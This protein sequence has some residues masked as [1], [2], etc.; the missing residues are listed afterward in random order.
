M[1]LLKAC[2]KFCQL[3]KACLSIGNTLPDSVRLFYFAGIKPSLVH[4]GFQ[5]HDANHGISTT[6]RLHDR[7]VDVQFRDNMLDIQTLLEIFGGDNL[8]PLPFCWTPPSTIY[9]LGANIGFSSLYLLNAFPNAQ[10]FAFEPEP[11]NYEIA[12]Q[13]LSESPKARLLKRAVASEHG[14]MNFECGTDIRGGRLVDA[15]VSGG[16]NI[17]SVEVWSIAEM[18]DLEGLP[19]PD[20]IKIDVEGAEMAVLEGMKSYI[21]SVKVMQIETH[22]Q[23]LHDSCRNFLNGT[24][25]EIVKDHYHG[26]FGIIWATRK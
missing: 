13:N 7:P 25:L 23:E 19:C 16:H 9:D 2:R 10:L 15:D 20:Y 21:N 14:E 24:D 8:D 11:G 12:R 26:E 5:A 4:R 1:N 22:S 6:L 3:G 18:I 17:Q